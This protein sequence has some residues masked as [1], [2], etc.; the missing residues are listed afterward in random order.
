PIKRMI[1]P[2]SEMPWGNRM[3]FMP[4]TMPKLTEFLNPLD[5]VFKAQKLI[6][7][8][9]SSF[10]VYIN[11]KM[12]EIVKKIGGYEIDR[13]IYNIMYSSF[14]G[15]GTSVA[16]S[17]KMHVQ[18]IEELEPHD[19]KYE[20]QRSKWLWRIIQLEDFTLWYLIVTVVDY[21]GKLR[22]AIGTQKG[23]IDPEKFKACMENAFKMIL[24]ATDN[25]SMRTY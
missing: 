4:V 21:M 5:F 17:I 20:G 22:I 9:R 3:A 7:R 18:Q 15:I 1:K 8:K 11:K 6:K 24:E 12:L 23:L 2:D 13:R 16:G 25:I 14:I 19:I 10:S